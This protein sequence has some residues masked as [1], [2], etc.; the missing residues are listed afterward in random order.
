M[1]RLAAKF[2][3]YQFFE[4]LWYVCINLSIVILL[5]SIP[6]F[7]EYIPKGFADNRFV[8]NPDPLVLGVNIL[9]GLFSFFSALVSLILA[10]VL[11]RQRKEERMALFLSYFLLIHGVFTSGPLE[12]LEIYIDGISHLATG[13][14]MPFIIV[15]LLFYFF[16][17]FPDG[18]FVPVWTKKL[19]SLVIFSS[20][21]V[22]FLAPN[23]AFTSEVVPAPWHGILIITGGILSLFFGGVFIY[24][25]LYRW[26]YV[27]SAEQKQQTKWVVL[28]GSVWLSFLGISSIPWTY[29]FSLPET[30]PFPVWL[31][32]ASAMW[33][34]ANMII[35]VSFTLAVMR[36]RLYDVDV[37]INRALAY[38]ALTGVVAL[39]YV[40][41]VGG[42]GRVFQTSG[43]LLISLLGTGVVAVML[44]PMRER[45]Q[46]AVN[47]LMY[48]ER[49]D[50]VSVMTMLGK[51]LEE[52][53]SPQDALSKIVVLIAKILKLPYVA[54]EYGVNDDAQIIASFGQPAKDLI[55]FPIIYQAQKIGCLVVTPRSPSE[56]FS[57]KDNI[58]LENIA[59][60]AGAAA[61]AARLTADLQ[62]SRQRLVTAREEERRR[63]RR[64]LH[65]DL[66]PTMAGQTLK[67]DA[68][69]D[70]IL[71]DPEF[72]QEQDLEEAII[73][74]T[75][76]KEQ[77]QHT[78]KNIR[79][80]V[81]ALRP[82]TLDD[83][84]L[85][86]A[87]QI[88]VDQLS[89]SKQGLRITF[90]K[91][92][93][94]IPRLSAAVEL[95]AYRIVLEAL[96][97]VINHAQAQECK[98]IIFVSENGSRTLNLEIFDDGIGLP[99]NNQTGIGLASMR[100]RA[101]ELGGTFSI[102]NGKNKGIRVLAY[103]PLDTM[104]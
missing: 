65:D 19:I 3:L 71:G 79:H 89:V 60:Q 83:L 86:A 58:L 75:D 87:I 45:L 97:N 94:D 2:S 53:I 36:Y 25:Q 51:Q 1:I 17:R 48:G 37:V 10:I 16:T 28:G 41:I 72:G 15:P 31:A 64:D 20:F 104:D 21:V 34:F 59:R 49:D 43:N 73:L 99:E 57:D 88:H 9:S 24:A 77:T 27:S 84:G 78:V 22:I 47:H 69:I 90:E 95:A 13:L 63:L 62:R 56:P 96:T 33:S 92:P 38:G 101:E 68:A 18:E 102:I 39:L 32:A 44:N 91:S 98:V 61:Q 6:G 26:R 80:I 85:V 70:L 103:I 74:L 42:L 35:P 29:S 55:Q 82:S 46:N 66:G 93:Q 54:I 7:M 67:L 40:V 23:T 12:L 4:G 8:V 52:T 14:V 76:L 81:Y 30:T 100:E 50:P 11:F 5:A